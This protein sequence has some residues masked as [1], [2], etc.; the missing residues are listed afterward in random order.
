MTS[1][2]HDELPSCSLNCF[3]VFNSK[4]KYQKVTSL[5]IRIHLSLSSFMVCLRAHLPVPSIFFPRTVLCV[6]N[7]QARSVS[8]A[9][10]PHIRIQ[11]LIPRNRSLCSSFRVY[12]LQDFASNSCSCW[13]ERRNLPTKFGSVVMCSVLCILPSFI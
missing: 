3:A 12:L 4:D 9:P 11:L 1:L 10:S 13:H 8:T 2:S 5:S 6:T 7:K